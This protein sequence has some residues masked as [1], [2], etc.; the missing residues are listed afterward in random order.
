MAAT[1]QCLIHCKP[2]RDIFLQDL[3]HPYQS[4]R[5][6]RV[7]NKKTSCLACEFDKIYLECYGS[8]IGVD[9]IAALE[10]QSKLSSHSAPADV[11][12]EEEDTHGHPIIPSSIL[13]ESW[14]NMKYLACHAQ[15]DAQ[16]YFNAFIDCLATHALAYHKCAEERQ[17]M[18]TFQVKRSHRSLSTKFDTGKSYLNGVIRS[19]DEAVVLIGP[20]PALDFIGN[21]FKGTLRS[22]LI[23]QKCGGKRA[24][25]EVFSNVSLPLAKETANVE[26]RGIPRRRK[27]SVEICLDHFTRPETLSDTVFCDSCNSKEKTQ[28]QQTFSKLPNVLCLHLKRFNS[29]ASKKITD[30]VSFP[31]KGLDMGKHLPHW[32]EEGLELQENCIEE[33]VVVE[34]PN[35][36]FDLFAT[37]N[38]RGTLNQGHYTATVKCGDRWYACNDALITTFSDGD[39]EKEVLSSEEAYMLFYQKRKRT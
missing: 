3:A 18:Q 2:L 38:H 7:G 23:C 20:I 34:S 22:V 15:H 36:L 28:K 35:I 9:V 10:E 27:I 4:C 14:R 24:Q 13:A 1:L 16:E 6:L 11:E 5:A 21:T 29:A 39:G 17:A 8:A 32:C 31:A 30:F 37:L 33:T 26:S 25:T 19:L 12:E